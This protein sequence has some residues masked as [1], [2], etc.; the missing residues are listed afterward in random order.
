M[1]ILEHRA[2]RGPNYYSR[3]QAIYMR[4]DIEEL[5]ERP[6]DEVA[7]LAERLEA[8][9]PSIYDHRCSVGEAGGFLQRVRNGTY[10]GHMVEHL[11]IELQNLVGFSVGYG[12]TV[13]SY[14][15]GIYNVVYRYRDEA[16][17]LAAG[18]AAVAIAQQLYDGEDVDLQPY[19]DH[20][21]EVRDANA[22]GPS[23]GAIV[24]AAK[25][26][27]IPFSNLTEG[28]S[29]TQLGHGVKQRRFQATVTDA[30]GIIGHSIADDKDWTKQI[31]G[32]AGV[33]VPQGQNCYSWEEAKEAAE[34]IGWP[35]VTKPLSGNHGRGVTTDIASMEDLRSGYDAAVERL[36]EESDGVIVESYIRGEDHRIL[37]IGGR[38]VAAAR[39]RPAHVVGD[40]RS[41]IQALIDCE[42]A[43]P[44]RGVG[45]ENLLTQIHVDEQTHRMLEQAG[46][47]LETVLPE[48]EIAFLKSTANISTGGTAMDL[49]DEVHPEVKFAME[50]IGR[51][52]GLDVIGIDLLAET[53]SRPLEEQSAG[54]VEVNAGPGFRMHMAPTHGTPRPVGEHVVD[55]LFPDPTDDGR[56][57][58]TAITGTNGKTTTTRLISH[59]LR[60]AGTSVGMGC[61]GT[62]EIDNHVILR[63]DYSGPAAAHAVL[64]EP[65]VEHAVLETARGGIMRRGLG[66]DE[67]DVGVLLNIA[68]DHL[69]ER[70]IHTLDELARCKTVI[71]DAVKREGGYCVLNADDPLVMEHGTYW[72]RGEI[73]YFT[74][75]PDNPE[76]ETHLSEAGMVLTVRHGKII[77]LRGKVT[78]DICE[79]NDV[80][81]AFEGHARFNVQNAMAAAAAAIAH[82]VEIDDVRAGLT[83]FHPTPTQMPGRTNYFEAD[84]VKCLIDYG[85]NV[86]ALEALEPLVRGLATQRRIGVASAPGNRR[87]EDLAALG[88][89][90]ARMCDTLYVFETDSRGRETGETAKLI[91]DG[92][93]GAGT[94]CTVKTV[95]QEHD[96]VA[97]AIGE[98]QRGDF[99]LLL[100]DD[101]EGTTERLKG[102]SFPHQAELAQA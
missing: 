83:T 35:V 89:Q 2:L 68:S 88:A 28:T 12:K 44:R 46:L 53:L 77:M 11:A 62:V 67:C 34:W 6:S 43:D 73:I 79:V 91:H 94:S 17:G 49:T 102:R 9:I 64:R 39:R 69:G 38:L 45:H 14:D 18:E 63:G 84:G 25:A 5:E 55:M 8:L 37:V 26:R 4:L 1:R 98:A 101:I 24:D 32:E 66:F 87:D 36:R 29:Y 86:P 22:L 70:D 72:A 75:D 16:T 23:T 40:G 30:S 85:H 92:A 13:D 31:L 3:Y 7:G 57:P 51:L 47:T 80:P 95:M 76:L 97:Q 81:I 19:I 10:A 52:V 65:T 20:L 56:I 27:N 33:P 99:L 74:M 90:L 58:I 15:A 82:G 54:V 41:T 59:I 60:Q 100:I 50:R 42:N 21:K 71:V 78:V 48:G 93:A 61:T 96:A